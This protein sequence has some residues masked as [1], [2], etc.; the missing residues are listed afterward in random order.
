MSLGEFRDNFVSV[1][2]Y[3]PLR[4]NERTS[5]FSNLRTIC[6][7]IGSAYFAGVTVVT[8]CRLDVDETVP[9]AE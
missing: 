9:T 6:L 5:E 2:N 3:P 7:D 4:Q 8:H 1:M